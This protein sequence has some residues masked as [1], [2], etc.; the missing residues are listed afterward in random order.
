MD[1]DPTSMI[2][3]SQDGCSRE[4]ARRSCCRHAPTAATLPSPCC[5]SCTGWGPW[6]SVPTEILSRHPRHAGAQD[7]TTLQAAILEDIDG[8]TTT[9]RIEILVGA[10]HAAWYSARPSGGVPRVHG[11]GRTG[12]A[13]TRGR[14]PRSLPIFDGGT[15]VSCALASGCSRIQDHE[16]R[17][18][19]SPVSSLPSP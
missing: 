7:R 6:R 14:V 5:T 8:C 9:S 3:A 1:L 16:A 13:G 12:T 11:G 10:C 18:G 17:P 4:R 15:S 19:L 2:M